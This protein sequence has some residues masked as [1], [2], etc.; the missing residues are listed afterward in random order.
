MVFLHG[1]YQPPKVVWPDARASLLG[2][3]TTSIFC[4]GMALPAIST[5]RRR[6]GMESQSFRDST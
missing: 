4:M 6:M 1:K 3:S 2:M 5:L